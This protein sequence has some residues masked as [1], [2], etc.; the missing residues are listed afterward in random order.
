M[1]R[2]AGCTL[3]RGHHG[4]CRPEI[5]SGK[6]E[7]KPSVKVKEGPVDVE[8]ADAA[9]ICA[10]KRRA[11]SSKAVSDRTF[12]TRC[13]R[14]TVWY[15]EDGKVEA[16]HGVVIRVCRLN[17]LLVKFINGGDDEY[18]VSKTEDEF[19][20]G[21]AYANGLSTAP[22]LGIARARPPARHLNEQALVAFAAAS[23]A[24]S[25][26]WPEAWQSCMA[27]L[28]LL[29]WQLCAAEWLK[30]A[31]P[32]ALEVVGERSESSVDERGLTHL[33]DAAVM[34]LGQV[35]KRSWRSIAD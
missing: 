30:R 4:S 2:S 23:S 5:L 14:I 25:R 13:P 28:Q 19:A 1:C 8:E 9:H 22:N 33:V 10:A 26:A 20:W 31:V 3:P 24:G 15:S 18:W 32:L 34:L 35:P 12:A 17:G 21:H 29:R 16:Y 27:T 11:G 6:R 7:R